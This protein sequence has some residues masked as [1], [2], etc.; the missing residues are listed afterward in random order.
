M[1]AALPFPVRSSTMLTIFRRLQPELV[2]Y[3]LA[4]LA[5]LPLSLALQGIDPR[6]IDGVDVWVKPAKFFVS[7][8]MFALTFAWCFALVRPERRRSPLMIGT[9]WLLI[10]ASA[11][12]IGWISWQA[13]HG[14]RSHFNVATPFDAMMYTTMGVFAVLF[15]STTVPLAWEI[16]RRPASGARRDLIAAV[17]IGLLLCFL[18]GG[19]L[20]GYL[21]SQAGHSVGTAAGQLPLFGWNRTGGDLRPG[22]FLGIHAMQAI[23][24]LALLTRG[25]SERLRWTVLTTGTLVYTFATLAIFAQAVAGRPLIG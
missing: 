17:V 12:E 5:M 9:V 22:H 13:A 8:A 25:L 11:Y 3:G 1:I 7:T 16:A 2:W 21:S 18:L 10:I 23:P 19:G 14:Q 6:Q 20:G 15:I 24:F 4:L